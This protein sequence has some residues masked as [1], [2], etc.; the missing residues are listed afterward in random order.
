MKLQ[1]TLAALLLAAVGCS[2]GT[3]IAGPAD[4]GNQSPDL[5]NELRERIR[6][7]SGGVG[8]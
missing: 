6:A 8:L 4:D 7:A 1:I 2:D 3:I 5:D